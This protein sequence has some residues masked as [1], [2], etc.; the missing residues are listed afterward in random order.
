[1]YPKLLLVLFNPDAEVL[2]LSQFALRLIMATFR[3]IGFQITIGTYYQSVGLYKK[4][5]V[6]SLL[7]QLIVFIPLLILFA[8]L[9]KLTGIWVSFPITDVIAGII[10][11]VIFRKD[12]KKLKVV[13]SEELKSSE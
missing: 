3:I 1:V 5:F 9:W 10:T 13:S 12:W 7:R 6:L 11:V 2:E 4:A 8:Q